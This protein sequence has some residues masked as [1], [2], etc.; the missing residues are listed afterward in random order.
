VNATL[1]TKIAKIDE[2]IA[3]LV[4][5]RKVLQDKLDATVDPGLIDVGNVVEFTTGRGA[6]KYSARGLVLGSKDGLFRVAVGQGFE[7]ITVVIPGDHVT[8]VEKA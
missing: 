5:E 2:A 4:A 1:H 6:K 3:K 8:K 7:A